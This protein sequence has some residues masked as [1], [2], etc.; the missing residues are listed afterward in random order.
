MPM[1]GKFY[2]R[3]EF[4]ANGNIYT[5]L[6]EEKQTNFNNILTNINNILREIYIAL[7]EDSKTVQPIFDEFQSNITKSLTEFYNKIK[8]L[9][10]L[11]T[12]EFKYELERILLKVNEKTVNTYNEVYQS[13]NKAT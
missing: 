11:K 8:I 12:E 10:Q 7:Y 13:I 6:N 5:I 9:P 1:T 3:M 2:I 4:D